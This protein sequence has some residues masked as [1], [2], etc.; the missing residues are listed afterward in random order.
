MKSRELGGSA[1]ALPW[2]HAATHSMSRYATARPTPPGIALLRQPEHSTAQ[3]SRAAQPTCVATSSCSC[4]ESAAAMSLGSTSHGAHAAPAA[5][6]PSPAPA[7]PL[8]GR[9][10]AS[11][12]APL[13]ARPA[14]PLLLRAAAGAAAAAAAMA[15]SAEAPET[16]GGWVTLGG[17]TCMFASQNAFV[18][19]LR[20]G[21]MEGIV[22]RCGPTAH[23]RGCRLARCSPTGRSAPR[24]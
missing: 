12:A 8:P 20:S 23:W 4:P 19:C 16:Q 1:A 17:H 9:Q 2:C 6:P 22:A 3:H 11:Q 24:V 13:G 21:S 14:P 10:V 18:S 7:P 15:P 5:P